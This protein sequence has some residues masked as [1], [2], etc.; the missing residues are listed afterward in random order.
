MKSSCQIDIKVKF[1]EK[2]YFLTKRHNIFSA[3]NLNKKNA[4]LSINNIQGKKAVS[5]TNGKTAEN[6][7]ECR[8]GECFPE[9]GPKVIQ[10]HLPKP[11]DRTL[12]LFKSSWIAWREEKV[13]AIITGGEMLKNEINRNL[14][15]YCFWWES[16]RYPL[17]SLPPSLSLPPSHCLS[18]DLGN[19]VQF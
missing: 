11:L 3:T 7:S 16:S 14:N 9:Q 2:A 18:T 8:W 6:T 13:K 4:Y 17:S 12:A 19:Y 10:R 5:I 15:F 1:Y